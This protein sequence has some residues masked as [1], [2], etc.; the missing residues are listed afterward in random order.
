MTNKMY[1]ITPS[2]KVCGRGR[3][4][5]RE[6]GRNVSVGGKS[7]TFFTLLALKSI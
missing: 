7:K 1:F 6:R 4:G 3:L 2:D 5:G